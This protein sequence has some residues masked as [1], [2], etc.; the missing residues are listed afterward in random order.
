[1]EWNGIVKEHGGEIH[2]YS[3][4]GQGTTFKLYFPLAPSV[5]HVIEESST[6]IVRGDGQKVLIVDDETDMC[7]V[8][9]ELLKRLGYKAAYVRSG[10]SAI[11][12]YRSWRP[13]VVLLD[14]NMPEMDNAK[15]VIISGYDEDGPSGIDEE[16][17]RLIK[18]YLTKPIEMGKLSEELAQVLG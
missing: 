14:R 10:N 18:G 2:V 15:I 5:E 9:E 8:M 11:L 16:K 6:E 17:K 13:D 12:K 1:M 7:R 4:L 3:E